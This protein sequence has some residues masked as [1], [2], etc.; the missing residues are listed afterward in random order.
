MRERD[1]VVGYRLDLK[2]APEHG[3]WQQRA[4]NANDE[5]VTCSIRVFYE[6]AT[7]DE[8]CLLLHMHMV[9]RILEIQGLQARDA[10]TRRARRT[11]PAACV[12]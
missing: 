5:P 10:L 2:L 9:Q 6:L 8:H 12:H 7:G 3:R 11:G 4:G 1:G